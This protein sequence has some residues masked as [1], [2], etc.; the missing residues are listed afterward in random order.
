MSEELSPQDINPTIPEPIKLA[1]WGFWQTFGLTLL[2]LVVLLVTQTIA[3]AV[4]SVSLGVPFEDVDTIAEGF[5]LEVTF[6]FAAAAVILTVLLFIRLKNS[7]SIKDYLCINIPVGKTLFTWLG[8]LIL[9]I[10]I[11]DGLSYFLGKEIVPQGTIDTY[12]SSEYNFLFFL[13]ILVFAPL[14]EEILFRGFMLMGMK[15]KE[16]CPVFAI[17]LSSLVWTALHIQYDVYYMGLI[18]ITGLLLGT[19]QVRTGSII[20]PIVLHFSSNLFATVELLLV[21]HYL[22]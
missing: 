5:M 19:A 13:S 21:V 3:M 22:S 9:L 2:A 8:L 14:F 7:L 20:V 6:P 4:V 10:L 11:T 18:F 15:P 17:V 12:L 16:G 1:R